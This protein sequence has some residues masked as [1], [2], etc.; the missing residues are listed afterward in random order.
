MRLIGL[1]GGTGSGKSTAA[2]RFE[3]RGIPVIDAD[4][5]GHDLLAP[6]GAAEN[7]VVEAFG[8]EV[9][10][11][12]I[13]DREKLGAVVFGDPDKLL[14]LNALVHPLLIQEVARQCAAYAE[15]GK[16]AVII[17]AA[18]LA[19]KGEK[20]AWLDALILVSAPEELRVARLGEGR[21]IAEETARQR[22]RMQTDPE[23]KRAC[24][25]WTID[26]SGTLEELH[27][28]VDA[29]VEAILATA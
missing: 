27:A 28:Q 23:T 12:G 10:S 9:T 17:D 8:P 5:V 13:I 1:T 24:S 14:Q 3:A 20:E 11:S 7:A 2:R 16:A 21:G 15:D 18:L 26:N 22:V 25:R 6:G 29:I 4:K 19:E